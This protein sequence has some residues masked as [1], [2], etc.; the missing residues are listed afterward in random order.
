MGSLAISKANSYV[1]SAQNQAKPLD[2]IHTII[3]DELCALR[4]DVDCIGHG[5]WSVDIG[6]FQH[7]KEAG[8]RATDAFKARI[9]ET[10]GIALGD[11]PLALTTAPHGDGP[12]PGN[13]KL[14]S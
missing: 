12:K 9:L 5:G 1:V 3:L 8:T 11:P 14:F 7:A 4:R 13:S 2:T 6:P 10:L